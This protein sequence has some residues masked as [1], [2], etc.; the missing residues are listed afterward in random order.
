M[1][2]SF[3][4][5]NFSFTSNQL[6]ASGIFSISTSSMNFFRLSKNS[7]IPLPVEPQ[8]VE[9]VVSTDHKP[10]KIIPYLDFD[11]GLSDEEE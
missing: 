6:L 10:E 2:F 4:F 11:I 1:K 9:P 8:P 5:S 3:I 7:V